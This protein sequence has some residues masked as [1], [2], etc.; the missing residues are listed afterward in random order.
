MI[1]IQSKQEFNRFIQDFLNWFDEAFDNAF[2]NMLQQLEFVL[3]EAVYDA[4]DEYYKT[5]EPHKYI[6][7]T[8]Q[9]FKAYDIRVVIGD[10]SV[11][12][13]IEGLDE[14]RVD[15]M[16]PYHSIYGEK[17]ALNS[18][19]MQSVVEYIMDGSRPIP[20][21]IHNSPY[22]SSYGPIRISIKQFNNV[23]VQGNSVSEVVMKLDTLDKELT[24]FATKVMVKE[25]QPSLKRFLRSWK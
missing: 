14:I 13:D 2:F 21:H 9:L 24:D 23:V 1:K 15:R 22:P 20:P 18:S 25:I 10:D 11:S 3:N 8:E 16:V 17:P 7:R 12:Y 5:W 4:I 6:P 19:Q